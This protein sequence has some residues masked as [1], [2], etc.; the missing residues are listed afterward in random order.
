MNEAL[1]AVLAKIEPG[2][3]RVILA[4]LQEMRDTADMDR[5]TALLQIGDVEGVVAMLRLS[6]EATAAMEAALADAVQTGARAAVA[7]PGIVFAFDAVNPA[8]VEFI[9]AYRLNLIRQI[10]DVTREGVRQIIRDGLEHGQNPRT[11]AR[12]VKERVGLTQ[13]QA[14]AVAN[15][16]AE[17]E[18]FH[19][20]RT[21]GDWN[22]GGKISR[23]A[24]GAQVYVIDQHGNPV[25]KI[26]ARRLRDFR[27]D[28]TLRRAMQTGEPLTPEQ[29]DK[30]VA[31]YERKFLRFRAETIART[32]ALRAANAGEHQQWVQAVQRGV[33][34]ESRIRRHWLTAG[35]ERVRLSHRQI[36]H[37]NQG[38]VMLNQPFRTPGGLVL[39]P[40]AAPNCR[41]T[42][43]YRVLPPR[44]T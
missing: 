17:L 30:M 27:F 1:K 21:A 44:A 4:A 12:A 24:G 38:G 22:L 6:A 25:D 18:R 3:R 43:T 20:K 39:T 33:V 15:F 7:P 35:D 8:T 11:V 41:C 2:L 16:R 5:L 23:A 29:I 40:P 32:E 34:E 19:L 42:V 26:M 31:A 13:S 10:D 36:P 9:R 28:R 37:M 14:K